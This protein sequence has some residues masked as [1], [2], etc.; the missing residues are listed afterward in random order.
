MING[1]RFL[2]S[3]G[4]HGYREGLDFQFSGMLERLYAERLLCGVFISADE[5]DVRGRE[6]SRLIE[7]SAV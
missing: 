4:S 6:G 2:P 5:A 3:H 1:C 7:S